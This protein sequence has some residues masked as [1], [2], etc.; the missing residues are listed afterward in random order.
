MA[1][2]ADHNPMSVS[3]VD[4][5]DNNLVNTY[6][7]ETTPAPAPASVVYSYPTCQVAPVPTAGGPWGCGVL[8]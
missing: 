8:W 3:A 6:W 2:L 1:R 5:G 7:L 4:K